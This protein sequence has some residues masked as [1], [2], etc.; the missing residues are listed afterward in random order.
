MKKLFP[1]ML[2][3]PVRNNS[4]TYHKNTQCADVQDWTA[5]HTA[6][7]AGDTVQCSL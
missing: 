1:P 5:E 4:C 7:E 6:V 2:N 3:F